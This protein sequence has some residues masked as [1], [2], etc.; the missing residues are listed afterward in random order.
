MSY[1][2][3]TE[4]PAIQTVDRRLVETVRERA[5]LRAIVTVLGEVWDSRGA[6]A[7]VPG[8]ALIDLCQ[9]RWGVQIW[10]GHSYLWRT[11]LLLE[12][13]PSE[14]TT[15]HDAY[16]LT[17]LGLAVWRA[18]QVS[19]QTQGETGVIPRFTT[20][21]G[22]QV[23]NVEVEVPEEEERDDGLRRDAE[24]ADHYDDDEHQEPP[25]EKKPVEK[26][27]AGKDEGGNGEVRPMR[28]GKR[29]G[30]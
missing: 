14:T 2:S 25:A 27:D 29:A 13:K 1:S 10:D 3:S 15:F 6:M 17:A 24:P 5:D 21:R 30:G 9:Q 12:H 8:K 18:L 11:L 23:G 16:R 28:R 19:V 4:E 26:P 22:R 7:F 20:K